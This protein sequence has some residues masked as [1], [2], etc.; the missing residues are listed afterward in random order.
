MEP[1]ITIK[2]DIPKEKIQAIIEE[3]IKASVSKAVLN[4]YN[5]FWDLT[6]DSYKR[7]M[8]A[9]EKDLETKLSADPFKADI[10]KKVKEFIEKRISEIERYVNI[11][12][13]ENLV[14]K[15][16]T[17]I[18]GSRIGGSVEQIIQKMLQ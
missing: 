13:I 6:E 3:T 10:D 18:V 17:H 15:T 11:I 7:I 2:I 12:N 1:Q 8:T 16:A 5:V 14:K 9:F 4:G